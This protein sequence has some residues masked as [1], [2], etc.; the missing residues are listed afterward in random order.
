M[1]KALRQRR[2]GLRLKVTAQIAKERRSGEIMRNRLARSPEDAAA[3]QKRAHDH[4]SP[5]EHRE[6]RCGQIAHAGL[7][8]GQNA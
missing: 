6:F 7:R 5:L 4:G 8:T 1:Q 2:V 3:C